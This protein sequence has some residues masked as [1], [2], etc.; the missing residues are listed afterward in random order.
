MASWEQDT[1][2]EDTRTWYAEDGLLH[3]Y[4]DDGTLHALMT[5]DAT[6]NDYAFSARVRIEQNPRDGRAGLIFRATE[7][8]FA[9]FRLHRLANK[10]Q[11]AYHMKDPF[12]WQV[13]A[14]RALPSPVL[15]DTWY[16]MQ[17]QA[18]GEHVICLLNGKAV[19]ETRMP[20]S[21]RGRVGFYSVD[22]RAAFDDALVTGTEAGATAQKREA[23]ET[24]T[25]QSFW[26]TEQ[27]VKQPAFWRAYEDAKPS[28]PWPLALGACLQLEDRDTD[29]LNLLECYDV[30]DVQ[31]QTLLACAD[32]TSG[33]VARH[34]GQRCYAFTISLPEAK[35][36]LVLIEKGERKVLGNCDDS[37]RIKRL[38][39]GGAGPDVEL[40]LAPKGRAARRSATQLFMLNL[41]AQGNRLRGGINGEILVD[42]RDDTLAHG[43]LGFY[44]RGGKALFM[45][46]H[47]SGPV[48]QP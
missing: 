34:D 33:L 38:L 25:L 6:W 46:L 44:A 28:P 22:S 35:A 17:V 43:R 15:G 21:R 23:I 18:A 2:G 1:G 5:G 26:F 20:Q 8:G 37:A 7:D 39:S 40:P 16:D 48:Q 47:A 13:L 12:G 30:H 41:I 42:V 31:F 32:G 3:Q 29:R 10:V 11:L 19:L 14:E 4:K 27:F 45:Q 24:A 9:L 36:S